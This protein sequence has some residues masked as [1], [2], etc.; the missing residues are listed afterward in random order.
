M[1]Y[2]PQP[3][4]VA[5]VTEPTNRHQYFISLQKLYCNQIVMV[6]ITVETRQNLLETSLY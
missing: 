1:N 3:L 2:I 6:N 5:Q 4:T